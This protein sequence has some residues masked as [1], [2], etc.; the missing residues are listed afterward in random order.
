MSEEERVV[1]AFENSYRV[2][3]L[4]YDWEDIMLTDYPFFA[5]NPSRRLPKI[6]DIKNL[7]NYYSD[8]RDFKKCIAIKRYVKEK[9]ITL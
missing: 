8:I 4:N 6:K 9:Q 2:I 3:I 5:H 1:M 7:M